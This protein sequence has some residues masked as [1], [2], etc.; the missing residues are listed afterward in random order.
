MVLPQYSQVQILGPVEEEAAAS[1]PI[2]V[3]ELLGLGFQTQLGLLTFYTAEA[4]HTGLALT[5]VHS[6]EPAAVA[7]AVAEREPVGLVVAAVSR[8]EPEAPPGAAAGS[9]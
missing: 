6:F 9:H 1:E 8:F 5:Y 7:L 3:L 4:E 2:G